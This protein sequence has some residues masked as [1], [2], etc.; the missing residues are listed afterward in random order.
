M[1]APALFSAHGI[2]L[3]PRP[4]FARDIFDG[5][6]RPG[7]KELPSK[8]LYDELG[9][10]LFEAICLLPE[11]GLNRASGRLMRRYAGDLVRRLPFP[12]SVAELG[13]GN[14]TNTR[15][16]LEALAR[17]EAVHYYPIDISPLALSRC[18]QE[19]GQIESVSLVGLERAY[20]DGLVEVAARRRAGECLLVLFLG[21]TIGNFDRPA[22][23]SFLFQVRQVLQ[24]G[25]VL[26]LATDLEKPVPQLLQAYDDPTGVTAAFNLNLLARINREMDADFDLAKFRHAVCW[27]ED[28]RRIEMH[29]HCRTAH[30]VKIPGAGC[31]VEFERFET[32]W[33]E[34]SHRY[35]TSEVI[36]LAR[37]TGYS[38]DA[39]WI[40]HE[41][42]FAHNLLVAG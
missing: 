35:N 24:P 7:Q 36:D 12:A 32:I 3:S 10:A 21:S 6:A 18:W 38:C 15:W 26:L 29:L 30:R 28:E 25:D 40:D 39:Q 11:Y 4:D 31:Q 34:S 27:N 8:Y 16:L 13:S 14:G 19:L 9:S 23:E 20:L 2:E 5:L 41:W 17:R 22:G 33:T 42:P 1:A 37:R